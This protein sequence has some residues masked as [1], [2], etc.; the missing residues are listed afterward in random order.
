MNPMETQ[1]V[2]SLQFHYALSTKNK[3]TMINDNTLNQM[4]QNA[5]A[6][7]KNAYVP[8]SKFAVGACAMAEDGELFVGCNVEN[9]SFGLTVCAEISAIVALISAGKKQLKALL[10][11]GSGPELC[12]P[13]GRCRQ[14]MRE[15]IDPGAPIYLCANDKIVETST[16]EKLLPKSFGPKNLQYIRG[17][18]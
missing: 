9:A 10:V 5:L 3:I 1:D 14:F 17:E 2:A 4:L 15:F 11:V 8:Y 18:K 16:I 13:C 7:R 12:T 6:V